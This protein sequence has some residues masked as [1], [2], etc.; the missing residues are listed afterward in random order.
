MTAVITSTMGWVTSLIS[1]TYGEDGHLSRRITHTALTFFA[2][3]LL[4]AVFQKYIFHCPDKDWISFSYMCFFIPAIP[5]LVTGWLSNTEF[6]KSIRGILHGCWNREERKR[7]RLLVQWRH[8]FFT[9]IKSHVSAYVAPFS[10]FMMCLL[11]RDI[12]TCA[13]YGPP[14]NQTTY[15]RRKYETLA[16]YSQLIGFDMLVAGTCILAIII[17]IKQ[18]FRR[19]NPGKDIVEFQCLDNYA[20]Y[21]AD[22]ARKY[23]EDALRA[24][25]EENGRRKAQMLLD[26]RK[27]N[28]DNLDGVEKAMGEMSYE[29]YASVRNALMQI[30][31]KTDNPSDRKVQ[32]YT[33]DA[34]HEEARV[35]RKHLEGVSSQ[36][37]NSIE[38]GLTKDG[39]KIHLINMDEKHKK[40]N[41]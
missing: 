34:F 27:P 8:L 30:Y 40:Y 21:E 10:W 1:S 12:M 14:S 31:P 3:A 28:L 22:A 7:T 29:H 15:V 2:T 5:L 13:V 41:V 11:N 39:E 20:S 32:Y 36:E 18:C 9:I 26:A 23:F 38:L 4:Q 25:A 35:F 37:P 24:Q 6:Q 16:V 17:T 19:A 33:I